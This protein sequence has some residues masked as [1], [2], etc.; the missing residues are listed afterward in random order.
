M[1]DEDTFSQ[2]DEMIHGALGNG[3]QASIRRGELGEPFWRTLEY[4]GLSGVSDDQIPTWQLLFQL[5]ETTG[6]A[7][8][9]LGAALRRAEV[10]SHR[11]DRMLEASPEQLEDLLP[12]AAALLESE[13]QPVNWLGA[14]YLLQ[15]N[16]SA[17]I[18]IA[19][20]FYAQNP[21]NTADT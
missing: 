18:R 11:V 3:E 16:E 6:H 1:I 9:E 5:V 10:N 12:R 2:I 4:A 19:R 17:R 20:H 13:D 21:E 15:D 14:Y 7:D 8:V